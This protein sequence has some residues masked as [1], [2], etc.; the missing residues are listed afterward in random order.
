[1]TL[2]KHH[3]SFGGFGGNCLDHR[4]IL[5]CIDHRSLYP[6]TKAIANRSRIA[7]GATRRPMISGQSHHFVSRRSSQAVSQRV[8]IPI[9]LGVS[10]DNKIRLIAN[11]NINHTMDGMLLRVLECRDRWIVQQ[12]ALIDT[13][14]VHNISFDTNAFAVFK[15]HDTVCNGKQ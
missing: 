3:G 6:S 15:S 9:V 10:Q 8:Q 11:R 12:S 1:M 4:W 2:T 7:T 5:R 13:K 14:L